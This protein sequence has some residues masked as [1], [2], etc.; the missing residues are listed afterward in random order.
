MTNKE[1]FLAL[2]SKEKTDTLQRSAERIKNRE[3]LRESQQIALKVLDKLDELNWTQRRLAEELGVS[4]QQ[5]SKI[6]SG[7]ENLTLETQVKLQ[8]VLN[9][10]IL[11]THY[12]RAI[13]KFIME[14]VAFTKKYDVKKPVGNAQIIGFPNIEPLVLEN[15][16]CETYALGA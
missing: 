15:E 16:D 6:V 9:I 8:N 1:K 7:K 10:P 11:A 14:I 4:P 5:V 2:V 12:E 3:I 13:K